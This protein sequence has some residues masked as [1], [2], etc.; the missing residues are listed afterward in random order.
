MIP[1]DEELKQRIISRLNKSFMFAALDEREKDIVV[2]AMEEKHFKKDDWVIKQGESGDN[3]YVVDQGELDCYKRFPN[4]Q[5]DTYLKV[6][7]PGE[8]FGE[9]ALLYNAP[10]AASIQSRE[11]CTLFSL[12][13]LTFNHIV[14]DAA[15]RKREKYV[16]VLKS[17]DLLSMMD[18]Y[19]RSHVA[20]GIRSA[21][22]SAGEC[23]I[24][25]GD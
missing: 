16:N 13:R 21:N 22:F 3:L 8:S 12:D 6:Y 23:I 5:E 18:P 2:N 4:T 7:K 10:R 20:D 19:E 24:R 14:K 15:M 1:K 9:L 17:I 11:D 25:E